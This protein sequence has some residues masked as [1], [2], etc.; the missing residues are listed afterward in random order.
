MICLVNVFSI[1]FIYS[2]RNGLVVGKLVEESQDEVS[3]I[4]H[5][6]FGTFGEVNVTWS[7]EE[8]NAMA[9][10]DYLNE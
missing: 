3:F 1:V 4:V 9:G 5:R 10:I 2:F 6:S 7:T 8:I